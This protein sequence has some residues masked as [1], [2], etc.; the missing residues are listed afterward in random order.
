MKCFDV[1]QSCEEIIRYDDCVRV[2][3]HMWHKECHYESV[4]LALSSM[5][6]ESFEHNFPSDLV[7]YAATVLGV[8]IDDTKSKPEGLH[9]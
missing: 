2:G 8:Y 4:M 9:P 7:Q 3:S 6:V 5:F 1:C